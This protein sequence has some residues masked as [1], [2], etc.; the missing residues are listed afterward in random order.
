MLDNTGLHFDG[1]FIRRP[2]QDGPEFLLKPA[3]ILISILALLA[4]MPTMIFGVLIGLAVYAWRGPREC[5]QA[6]TIMFVVL[7]L[8]PGIF[9]F[10]GRGASL[11]WLV[12]FSA[13]GRTIWDALFN[14]EAWP[15]RVLKPLC[16][17]FFSLVVISAV[18]SRLPEIS[19]FKVIAFWVG[20]TV[21]LTSYYRT[22][23]LNKYWFSWYFTI[24]VVMLGLSLPLYFTTLG[25]F[26]NGLGFQGIT[27]HPQTFGPI[28]A[29]VTA[30]LL[31]CWLF[32]G[33]RRMLIQIAIVMGLLAIITSQARTSMLM[34]VGSL[35]ISVG[36]QYFRKD[37]RE[38]LGIPRI[39]LTAKVLGIV[40]LLLMVS[41]KGEQI[42]NAVS[43]FVLKKVHGKA[44]ASIDVRASKVQMQWENFRQMPV[45]GIGFGIPSSADEWVG[46]SRGFLGIPTGFTIE[47]GFLPTAVLEETGI[48]GAILLLCFVF[49]LIRF[50]WQKGYEPELALLL[51]ALLANSGEAVFFSFGAMG[52]YF[53]LMIG[54][55]YQTVEPGMHRFKARKM[56]AT[57]A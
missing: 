40:A 52:L 9:P 42:N 51:A 19:L 31:A 36:F 15:V 43:S 6:L 23:H 35:V 4:I 41:W 21:I 18:A 34:L 12:L 57:L 39:P 13:F 54:L 50:V 32:R 44:S 53:W 28:T 25:F 7:N 16:V 14:R 3:V 2:R 46:V 38:A 8:N 45:T 27:I 37:G 17:F 55:A 24:Y 49:S 33:H 22:R 5:L 1:H 47:K 11:R 29:P 26:D 10:W 56:E 30:W 48:V 20:V